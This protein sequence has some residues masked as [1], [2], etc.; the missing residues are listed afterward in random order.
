M[1]PEYGGTLHV[2]MRQAPMSLD[3]GDTVQPDSFTRRSLTMLMFDTL[4]TIDENLQ[5][6]PAL[7]TVWQSSSGNQRW[8]L[9]IRRGVKFHDGTVLTAEAA[10]ASLRAA[11][12]TWRVGADGDLLVIE[13]DS[14][15]P[16]LLA[17]RATECD[18]EEE[19]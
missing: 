6:R 16:E 17:Q 13:R 8:Q 12:P 14:S 9:R 3:P 15:D 18:C 19:S 10:A 7:A 2:M 11:N 5:I 1:R 4:V